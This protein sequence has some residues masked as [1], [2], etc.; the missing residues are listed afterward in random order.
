MEYLHGPKTTRHLRQPRTHERPRPA[1]DTREGLP[2]ALS[3]LRAGLVR[4]DCRERTR[5]CEESR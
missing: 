2:A 3:V 5:A 4:L 1:G